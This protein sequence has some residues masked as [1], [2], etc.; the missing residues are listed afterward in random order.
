M[1]HYYRFMIACNE[2]E[3]ALGRVSGMGARYIAAIS[4]DLQRWKR[5]LHKMEIQG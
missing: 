3:L 4:E 2:W 1:K 5:A